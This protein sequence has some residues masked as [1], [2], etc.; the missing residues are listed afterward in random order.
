MVEGGGTIVASNS[1]PV[2]LSRNESGV[3][4]HT[5]VDGGLITALNSVVGEEANTIEDWI[6]AQMRD[7]EA[8]REQ[9]G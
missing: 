7:V 2:M 3:H 6:E 1:G 4:K 9:H 8:Y 5:R